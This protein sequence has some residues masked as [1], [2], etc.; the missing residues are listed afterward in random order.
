MVWIAIMRACA[1]CVQCPS[2]ASSNSLGRSSNLRHGEASL[3]LRRQPWRPPFVDGIAPGG[4]SSEWILESRHPL[5]DRWKRVVD[6]QSHGVRHVQW[7]VVA[8][9]KEI[10]IARV[11]E[12]RIFAGGRQPN[13]LRSLSRLGGGGPP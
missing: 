11:K 7:I 4:R 2:T 6:A 3:R 9:A 10:V 5:R 1:V 8:V 13:Y 12:L